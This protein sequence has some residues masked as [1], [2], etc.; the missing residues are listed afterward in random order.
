MR[1]CA[2]D[3]HKAFQSGDYA[4]AAEAL[5]AAFELADKQPHE[6]GEHIEPHSY[7]A[8]KED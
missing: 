4:A 6:E 8:Q 3:L 5:Q 7:D 2:M 1:S